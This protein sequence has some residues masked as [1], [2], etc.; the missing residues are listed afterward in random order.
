MAGDLD[1]VTGHQDL[2]Q[3]GGCASDL[4]GEASGSDATVEQREGLRGVGG[5][6]G[7][8]VNGHVSP[9]YVTTRTQPMTVGG[10]TE[11]TALRSVARFRRPGDAT[12]AER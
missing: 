10:P 8:S 5:G 3:V 6:A 2:V 7:T 9:N 12:C 4:M 11:R 1:V